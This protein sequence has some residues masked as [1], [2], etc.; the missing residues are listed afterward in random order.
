MRHLWLAASASKRYLR[1]QY[2]GQS[3][4]EAPGKQGKDVWI[5]SRRQAGSFI[6]WLVPV[7]KPGI[8]L[9]LY[10]WV[11]ITPKCVSLY[12][13][14]KKMWS[15]YKKVLS[16]CYMRSSRRVPT[17]RNRLCRICIQNTWGQHVSCCK[18]MLCSWPDRIK[19][20]NVL[21]SKNWVVHYHG[22]RM[23]QSLPPFPDCC[24]KKHCEINTWHSSFH[25][26]VMSH[27]QKCFGQ[28]PSR[29]RR[30]VFSSAALRAL[31]QC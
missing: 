25:I 2:R 4:S 27:W 23:S 10:A 21:C 20:M 26:W 14:R 11:D 9:Y 12:K 1:S 16:T 6:F 19:V 29:N 30:A 31:L 28:W 7:R 22:C 18:V 17:E 15:S 8:S 5:T 24:A 3:H 13:R